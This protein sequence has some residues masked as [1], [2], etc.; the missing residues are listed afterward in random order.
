M[1]RNQRRGLPY[2]LSKSVQHRPDIKVHNQTPSKQKNKRNDT[3]ESEI[4]LDKE[5]KTVFTSIHDI[6]RSLN[7]RPIANFNLNNRILPFSDE[8]SGQS[9]ATRNDAYVVYCGLS[10]STRKSCDRQKIGK[11]RNQLEK[12]INV[13]PKPYS[14]FDRT[15]ANDTKAD[16]LVEKEK[17]ICQHIKNKARKIREELNN[18]ELSKIISRLFNRWHY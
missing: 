5:I 10:E 15:L 6:K 16:D 14:L 13:S 1:R 2:L 17:E 9:S 11:I 8:A 3:N 12:T 18:D 7:S 4:G